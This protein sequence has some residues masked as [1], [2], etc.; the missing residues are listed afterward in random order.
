M[1]N[2]VGQTTACI[3]CKTAKEQRF[4]HKTLQTIGCGRYLSNISGHHRVYLLEQTRSNCLFHVRYHFHIKCHTFSLI[5][6]VCVLYF[7]TPYIKTWH[8]AYFLF[9]LCCSDVMQTTGACVC[10]SC[11]KVLPC[12]LLWEDEALGLNPLQVGRKKTS[13]LMHLPLHCNAVARPVPKTSRA[14]EAEIMEE[15][16][17]LREIK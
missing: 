7:Y 15:E 5:I 10:V 4:V 14:K 11:K 8:T 9:H 2:S 16:S 12:V 6:L 3:F 13:V 1:F 17:D